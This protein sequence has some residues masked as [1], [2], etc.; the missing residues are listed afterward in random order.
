MNNVTS[1]FSFPAAAILIAASLIPSP[2]QADCSAPAAIA[3][4]LEYFAASENVFKYCDGTNWIAWGDGGTS[5]PAGANTQIQF[6]SSGAFGANT[7]FVWDNINGWLGIGTSSPNRDAPSLFNSAPSGPVLHIRDASEDLYPRTLLKLEG[8]DMPALQMRTASTVAAFGSKLISLRSGGSIDSPSIVASGSLLLSIDTYG[9]DGSDYDQTAAGIGFLVDGTPGLN[10]M[11]GRIAFY[12]TLD[13]NSSMSQRMVI[14][15]DG[16]VGIGVSA[17]PSKFV[18]APPASAVVSDAGTIT[19][20]ACGTIK[21]ITSVGN[22]TT[23]TTDTFTSS[24]ASYA[25][26]CMDVI[27]VD[28]ADTITLDAN[29]KFKTIGGTDQALG[30]DDT[31]RV[32][33]N[34]TNWYQ[35]GAVSGNQ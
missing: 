10:D 30:P 21:Q 31:V 24:T 18:V 11:P 27:N 20:D 1:R 25:G 13:G 33:S 7:N 14:K 4:T 32:C 5:L 15:N 8:N 29:A 19:A 3:G 12:T 35:V 16:S 34:G 23:N 22:V 26:C 28:T 6:N 9:Y 17:P 2:A